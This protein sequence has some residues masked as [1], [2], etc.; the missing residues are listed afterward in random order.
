MVYILYIIHCATSRD[1]ILLYAADPERRLLLL[2]LVN[3]VLQNGRRKGVDV[4]HEL[5]QDP[6]RHAA[7]LV[8]FDIA[9]CFFEIILSVIIGS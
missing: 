2:Y 9:T 5:Y 6:L 7:S 1:A 4:Y 3:D 8:R